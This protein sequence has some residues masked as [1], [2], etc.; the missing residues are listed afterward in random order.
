MVCDIG[1]G[2]WKYASILSISFC[3]RESQ[4]GTF[5]FHSSQRLTVTLFMNG[6]LLTA[7]SSRVPFTLQCDA[8]IA[9][10]NAI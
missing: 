10:A 9:A 8:W 4:A 1:I 2:T 5:P 6:T 7:E 3:E